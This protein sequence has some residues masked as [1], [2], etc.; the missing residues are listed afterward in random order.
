MEDLPVLQCPLLVAVPGE[1]SSAPTA[2]AVMTPYPKKLLSH[3]EKV[4]S[5]GIAA[6]EGGGLKSMS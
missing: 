4:L 2:E 6:G 1:P 3:T 5:H